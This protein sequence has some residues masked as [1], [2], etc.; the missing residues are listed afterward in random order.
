MIG[1]TISETT[2]KRTFTKEYKAEVVG[3]VRQAGGNASKIAR[4]IELSPQTVAVWVRQAATDGSEG[5]T[6]ALTTTERAEL[7]LLRKEVR[8]LR[9]EREFLKKT[10]AWFAKECK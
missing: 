6:T 2:Q 10:S 8:D 7:S 3:L 5:E 9:L 1:I 4:D